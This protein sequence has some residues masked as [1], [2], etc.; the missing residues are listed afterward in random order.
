[1]RLLDDTA[2]DIND[3]HKIMQVIDKVEEIY[4]N[5]TQYKGTQMIF[6]DLGTPTDPNKPFTVYKAIKELLV[7]RG[8]PEEEIAFV[9]DADN[10]KKKIQLSRK[11]N[12]GEVR[13]LLA[14]TEKGGTGLNVQ[15]RMKAVHHLD[16]PWRPSDI[17]QRNGRLVRQGNI[18]KTVDIYHYITTGSFDNYLWQIQETK[19][20]YISQ[21]MTSKTPVRAAED[22]DEQTMT[23][24]DFKAIATGNPYLKLQME[25]QNELDLLTSQEKSWKREKIAVH[26]RIVEATD[27]IKGLKA[28]V[29]KVRLDAEVAKKN[30]EEN[31]EFSMVIDGRTYGKDEKT[32]ASNQ[33]MY[34]MQQ[35]VSDPQKMVTMA[36]YKGF[37]LKM[38][39]QRTPYVNKR[40]LSLNIVGHNQYSVDIDFASALGTIQRI[41]NVIKSI[42]KQE[43][44]IQKD[45]DRY[46]R[47][48]DAGELSETFS[49][50]SRLDYIAAK[51][52]LLTPLIVEEA[53]ISTIEQALNS[54]EEKYQDNEDILSDEDTSLT[55]SLENLDNADY[56]NFEE[57]VW[58]EDDT[59]SEEELE[60]EN[61]VELTENES[62]DTEQE[63]VP[64]ETN[65]DDETLKNVEIFD[66]L[67]FLDEAEELLGTT[68]NQENQSDE[69][70]EVYEQI[71]LF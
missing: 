20:K 69:V 51:H 53:D 55:S 63:E 25:L 28:R 18:Y 5:E 17:I 60:N 48:V 9:H 8:I 41:D 52:E 36:T 61:L 66:L 3:G 12:V 32:I 44:K 14:S 31:Q 35:N 65:S 21:I 58:E 13:I 11:V 39:S 22:I 29:E 1:M 4:H 68:E 37:D 19:L 59:T 6:S 54:F 43:E 45:I 2:F 27:T 46:Q 16:V 38:V 64:E 50:A 67:T 40:I 26:N 34:N 47:I 62:E 23:A 10:E 57:G 15:K 24:S 33:L 30:I 42:E 56:S 49:K 70:D 71:S 7:E